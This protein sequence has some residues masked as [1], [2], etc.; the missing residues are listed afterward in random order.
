[1]ERKKTVLVLPRCWRRQP[2]TTS[3]KHQNDKKFGSS[4]NRVQL[5]LAFPM[6]VLYAVS[7][8]VSL[9]F[10]MPVPCVISADVSLA[11]P[12]PV[13]YVIIA[14]VS[15]AFAMSVVH[16]V[17]VADVSLAFPMPVPYVGSADVSLAFPMPVVMILFAT[18]NHLKTTNKWASNGIVHYSEH[19]WPPAF[20]ASETESNTDLN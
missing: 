15:L 9:A 17:S 6:P 3:S 10:P 2:S 16:I 7:A 12:V 14:D 5:S 1:M 20:F 11:F 19:F 4:W 18:L 8:N 13:L